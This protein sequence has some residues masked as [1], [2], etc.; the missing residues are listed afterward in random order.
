M[1]I[2]IKENGWTIWKMGKEYIFFIPDRVM[3]VN[4]QMIN[5]IKREYLVIAMEIDMKESMKMDKNQAE[6]CI[7][8]VMDQ[9]IKGNGLGMQEVEMEQWNTI[10][11]MCIKDFGKEERDM[12]KEYINITMEMFMKESL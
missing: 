11:E 9:N 10:M 4:G 2:T 5:S 12:V 7:I 6:V 3:R 8:I 1:V